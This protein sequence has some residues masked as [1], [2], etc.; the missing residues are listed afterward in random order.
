MLSTRL[1]SFYGNYRLIKLLEHKYAY[2]YIYTY[3]Y[4][5]IYVYI[6]ICICKDCSTPKMFKVPYSTTVLSGIMSKVVLPSSAAARPSGRGS[7]THIAKLS[8]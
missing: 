7:R 6:Y 8:V 1:P 5:Y 4:I 3:I 2:I